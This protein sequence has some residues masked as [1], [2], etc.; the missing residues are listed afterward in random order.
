MLPAKRQNAAV[1][2]SAFGRALARFKTER[3]EAARRRAAGIGFLID[4]TS[5][6]MPAWAEAQQIQAR[7]FRSVAGMRALSLRLVHFGG[8]CL[9]DHGWMNSPEKVAATMREIQCIAGPTQLLPGLRAFLQD[10]QPSAIILV[11]DC[12]EENP[13]GVAAVALDLRAAGIRVFSFLEGDDAAAAAVFRELAE[14][15][16]GRFAWFGAELP[17]RDLCEGVALLTAGGHRAIKR[18][19]NRKVQQLLLTGPAQK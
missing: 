4:A 1:N 15:T 8:G 5:S 2:K 12:F 11:G 19:P 13:C 17:L 9:T 7:M 10:E 16:G 3:K 14:T 18:L 6:R